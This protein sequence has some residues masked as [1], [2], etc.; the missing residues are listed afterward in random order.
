VDPGLI[1]TA[2]GSDPLGEPI[3]DLALDPAILLFAQLYRFG[4]STFFNHAPN[5]DARERHAFALEV[6]VVEE[7]HLL[8]SP[9]KNP[10]PNRAGDRRDGGNGMLR[11]QKNPQDC[12]PRAY[13]F[14]MYR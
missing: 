14:Q 3:F 8:V 5:M 7:C 10:P 6:L 13:R 4:K 9:T 12:R 11:A 2:A 1:L